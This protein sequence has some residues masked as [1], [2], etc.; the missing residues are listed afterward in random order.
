MTL[1]TIPDTGPDAWP[2]VLDSAPLMVLYKHS[3]SCLLSTVARREV[4]ALDRALPEIPVYQVDVIR[5]HGLSARIA[6]DL[7]VRHESPQVILIRHGR[8]AWDTS[9]SRVKAGTMVAQLARLAREAAGNG[10][11]A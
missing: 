3:P 5:E 8:A 2:A 1:R 4:V 7:Q 10:D 6:A 9:H 11:A